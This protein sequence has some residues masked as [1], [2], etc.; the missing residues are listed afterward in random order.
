MFSNHK[1]S[2]RYVQIADYP[3]TI[4]RSILLRIMSNLFVRWF[5]HW[6][7]PVWLNSLFL[8]SLLWALIKKNFF[9]IFT[10][11]FSYVPWTKELTEKLVECVKKHGNDNWE[12]G[13]E[14]REDLGYLPYSCI[15]MWPNLKRTV[16]ETMVPLHVAILT[17]KRDKL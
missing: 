7:V 4:I 2:R 15:I 12:L 5:F 11:F 9:T 6:S 17:V 3:V 16:H 8:M 10:I 14:G 13:K 1:E